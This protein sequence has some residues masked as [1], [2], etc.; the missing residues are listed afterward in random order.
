VV[1]ESHGFEPVLYDMS[2]GYDLAGIRSDRVQAFVR[3][4]R[5]AGPIVDRLRAEVPDEWRK[6]RHLDFET[7]LSRTLTLS[8]FHGC[9]PDEIERIIDFLLREAGLHCIVKLNPTL[10]GPEE[11]RGLLHDT[12]GYEELRIP[13]AAFTRDTTWEQMTGFVERL[14]ETAASLGLGF[15][16]KFSNTLIVENHRAFFPATEKEMYLSGQPLHVLTMHLVARFRA[17]ATRS[18]SPRGS[19]GRTS[20]TRSRSGSC[21]S[22]CARTCCA[23]ADTGAHT[24]TSRSWRSGWGTS[25]RAASTSSCSARTG[26]R[27]R[28][29]TTSPRRG[30]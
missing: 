15:G 21:R 8:T 10:L 11:A 14:G 29:A 6:L 1:R 13:D 22:R 26:T 16:V 18:R 3:G 20:R 7:D 4:M 2:V 5:N 27:R 24:A 30:S 9:P 17:I 12:L 23:P 28:P 19:T 25:A